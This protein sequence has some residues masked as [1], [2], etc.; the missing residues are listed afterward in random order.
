MFVSLLEDQNCDFSSCLH[1]DSSNGFGF[2]TLKGSQHDMAW[3]QVLPTGVSSQ[4]CNGMQFAQA[5]AARA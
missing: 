4:S 1:D 2:Q 3:L 5:I